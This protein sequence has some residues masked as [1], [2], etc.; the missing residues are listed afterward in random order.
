MPPCKPSFTLAWLFWGF[1]CL[2]KG[3]NLKVKF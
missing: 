3:L 2:I 1:C